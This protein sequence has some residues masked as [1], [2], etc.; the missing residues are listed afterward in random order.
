MNDDLARRVAFNWK[1]P[2]TSFE[3]A[4]EVANSGDPDVMGGVANLDV[5]GGGG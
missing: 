3:K 1:L 4:V 2:A 5:S